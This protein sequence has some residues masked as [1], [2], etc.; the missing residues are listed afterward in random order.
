[1]AGCGALLA[2]AEQ[3]TGVTSF[4]LKNA[5]RMRGEREDELLAGPCLCLGLALAIPEMLEGFGGLVGASGAPQ[6]AVVHGRG[7]ELN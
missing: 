4:S 2:A 7:H 5:R 6:E 1:V 3:V